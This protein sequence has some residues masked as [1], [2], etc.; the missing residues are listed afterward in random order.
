MQEIFF[1]LL[2][3]AAFYGWYMGVRSVHQK[4]QKKENKLSRDY[5]K[6]L[7]FLLSDQPDK[8]VDHFIALLEVDNETIETHLA[9]GN[10][11]RQ[12]GEVERS[13]RIH[14]NL[15]AR[16]SLTREQR[17]LALLQLGKDFYQAGLFDR[18]EK[19]FIQLKDSPEYKQ[20]ALEN[21]LSIYQQLKE[22]ADAVSVTEMLNK[23]GKGKV[24]R[25]TLS[26]LYCSLADQSDDEKK[27]VALYK[28]ALVMF[29]ACIK[30]SLAL[31]DFYQRYNK[32]EKAL[33]ILEKIPEVDI[34]FSE[35]ILDKLL[36]LHQQLGIEEELVSYLYRII[37]LGAGAS[38]VILLSKLIERLRSVEKAQAFMLQELRKNPTMKG[39]NQLMTYHLT[40]SESSSEVESLSFLQKLV[41]QQIKLRPQYRCQKCGYSSN[42][43]HWLCPSCKSWGRIKPIRGLDGE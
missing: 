39:F 17:D 2:P 4:N 37:S 23:I 40:L 12:R 14:Q 13:I 32:P 27:Q 28:K 30:A 43:L 24:K 25:R 16:P 29:P 15:I 26:Y 19:I 8:A 11:F 20:V 1:L 35:V 9:L 21:L 6:G 18:S 10:L 42:K 36:I 3:V 22:W 7:N 5:V 31:C 34:D 38:S 33:E 41:A